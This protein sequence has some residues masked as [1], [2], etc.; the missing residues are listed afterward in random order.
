MNWRMCVYMNRLKN[1]TY[2]YHDSSIQSQ[3]EEKIKICL[4]YLMK[5]ALRCWCSFYKLMH[6][7]IVQINKVVSASNF[8]IG[9]AVSKC[10]Y[11]GNINQGALN[12]FIYISIYFTC[13]DSFSILF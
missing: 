4:N 6:K 7:E 12:P 5:I 9:I 8:Y 10:S 11:M 1:S 3:K 13:F 2:C